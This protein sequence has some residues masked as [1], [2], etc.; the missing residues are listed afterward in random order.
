ML[1]PGMTQCCH[2]DLPRIAVSPC[3]QRHVVP[4]GSETDLKFC[5]SNGK[6]NVEL[7]DQLA[8][9]AENRGLRE[10][11]LELQSPTSGGLLNRLLS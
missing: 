8:T 3:P 1:S 6:R 5:L 9:A 2:T 11:L 4:F 10:Q 7:R